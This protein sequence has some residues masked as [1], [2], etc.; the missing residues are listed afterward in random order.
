VIK[1]QKFGNKIFEEWGLGETIE[2][3]KGMTMLFH[4]APG[5]GKTHGG[6]CIAKCLGKELLVI[7]PSQ[8][9]SSEPGGANRAIE[10]AFA[11]ATTNDKVLFF[12]E[13][14]GLICKRE[15]VGMIIGSEINTLLTSIE[16]FEGVCILCT[17]M[18]GNLDEA[19]ER[20]L[21]LIQEFPK[22]DRPTREIIWGKMIP[23]KMPVEDGVTAAWLS[24]SKLTGGQI[25][26]VLL[27]AARRA[28][29]DNSGCVTKEHFEKAI[30][31]IKLSSGKMGKT[32]NPWADAGPE[33]GAGTSSRSRA[34]GTGSDKTTDKVMTEIDIST[35]K[36]Q[37]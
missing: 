24:K 8:I 29:S 33:S 27:S 6:I 12:D 37:D 28:V 4:G 3:G 34:V 2:Y 9:Q 20:R 17:N 23:S 32:H 5:T 19:L 21:S 35:D 16:K 30:D 26:N 36:Q 31:K 1:Q 13:C 10:A 15:N 18:I 25:K 14:D 7:T 22:P 11:E